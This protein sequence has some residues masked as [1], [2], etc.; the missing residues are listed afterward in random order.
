MI[1]LITYDL[2]QPGRNYTDLYEAIKSLGDWQHPLE[3]TW[4][5]HVPDNTILDDIVEKLKASADK[6]DF[7]FAVEI[8]KRYQGWLPKSFWTWINQINNK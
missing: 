5:V 8:T 3:S 4:F 2:K 7:F 1:V 6:N